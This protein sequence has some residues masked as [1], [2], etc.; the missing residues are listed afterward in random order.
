MLDDER[1][2]EAVPYIKEIG[3]VKNNY[4]MLMYSGDVAFGHGNFEEAKRLWNQ[5][6]KEYPDT[7]QAY[8]SRADRFKKIGL[9]QETMADYEKCVEMQKA[10]HIID[11]LYSFAQMHELAGE[12]KAAIYDNE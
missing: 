5:S 6:V 3:E 2:D 9:K 1:Y 12:Y 7:W 11:E 10:P 8:C 4:Q